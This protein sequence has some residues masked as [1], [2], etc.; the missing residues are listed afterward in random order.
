[1]AILGSIKTDSDKPSVLSLSNEEVRYRDAVA[2]RSIT[3]TIRP[4]E[5]VAL[6]GQSGAGK[7]T[8]LRRLYQ[9]APESCAFIHQHYAL[10]P[11]LSVFHNIFMGRLDDFSSLHN[12]LNLFQPRK[13]R[14][15]EI[16]PIAE[17]LGLRDKMFAK[18]GKLSGGQQQR[19]GIGRALYRGG[20]ILMADEPVS[21]LDSVQGEEIIRL[22][23]QTTKT[24]ISSLHSIDLSE[25]FFHRIIGLRHGGIVFDRPAGKIPGRVLAELYHSS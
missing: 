12:F 24:V 9:L 16:A 18:V 2:L 4:G 21:S 11:Q 8:L 3:L 7:T 10:V 5:K 19:V 6:V 23:T 17:R 25:K 20:S 15:E 1:M 22:I 13:G 14:I